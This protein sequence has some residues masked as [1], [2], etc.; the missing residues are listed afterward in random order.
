M[1]T[2]AE[3]QKVAEDFI[4]HKVSPAYF[5]RHVSEALHELARQ[6]DISKAPNAAMIR[7]AQA[8]FFMAPEG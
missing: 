3:I 5:A 7:V 1:A 8:L 4:R 2:I 6:A